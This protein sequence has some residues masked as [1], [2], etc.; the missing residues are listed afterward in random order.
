LKLAGGTGD[1]KKT[2]RTGG[3]W[4]KGEKGIQI[5]GTSSWKQRRLRKRGVGLG[6]PW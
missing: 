4:K 5:R 3:K 2:I 1:E 6:L